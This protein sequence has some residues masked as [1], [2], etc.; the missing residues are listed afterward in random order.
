MAMA[1][2]IAIATTITISVNIRLCETDTK[3]LE[4]NTRTIILKPR[5]IHNTFSFAQR[6][7]LLSM[8][9]FIQA[10]CYE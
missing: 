9:L 2:A 6:D 1:I 8:M 7:T 3:L 4:N 5:F 10:H